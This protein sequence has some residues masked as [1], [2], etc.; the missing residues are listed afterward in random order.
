M[1]EAD[2][3]CARFEKSL[4]KSIFNNPTI[5]GRFRVV[6]SNNKIHLRKEQNL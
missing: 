5:K 2:L 3:L 1:T 4:S 6:N